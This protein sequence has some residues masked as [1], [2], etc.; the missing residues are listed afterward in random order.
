MVALLTTM[1]P[2]TFP[3]S[4]T[5]PNKV[6]VLISRKPSAM[7]RTHTQCGIRYTGSLCTSELFNRFVLSGYVIPSGEKAMAV[8]G[9]LCGENLASR[10]T[11]AKS[12]MRRVPLL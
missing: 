7:H 6:E 8:T 11:V 10:S 9:Q 3:D 12:N 2:C 4:N 1:T 5:L